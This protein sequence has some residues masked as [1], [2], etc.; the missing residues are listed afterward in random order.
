MHG[1]VRLA[2]ILSLIV[3]DRFAHGSAKALGQETFATASITP[4]IAGAGE[5][6]AA[7]HLRPGGGFS[8]TNATLRD[9]VAHAY[10]RHPFDSRE[11]IG[12]PAW[13][14]N[15]R[16]DVA[17]SAAAEHVMDA[18]GGFRRTWAMLGRLLADR[19]NVKLHEEDRDRPVYALR[20]LRSDGALGPRLQ[21]TAI[22]CG[23]SMRSGG[24]PAQPGKGPPCST[25][26]PPGRLFANTVSLPTIASLLSRHLDRVVID[27]TGLPGRFDVELEA[28]DITAPPDYTA[29]PSDAGLPPVR[30][31]SIFAAI[32]EQLG[33]RL[34]PETASVRVI[35]IDRAERPVLD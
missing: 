29:G 13:I 11:V 33:L 18:D 20:L 25:K 1:L 10:Q 2:T 35:V 24:P 17:A 30:G 3:A 12:G 21:K 31:P 16:F 34:E 32:R 14:D 4:A 8:A 27:R 9:L 6:G 19:F 15:E 26:N 23:E 28:I 22:D 7:I 5:S